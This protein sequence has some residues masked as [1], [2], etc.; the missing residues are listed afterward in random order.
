MSVGRDLRRAV[1]WGLK[2]VGGLLANLALLTIWVDGLG[3]LAWWAVGINWVVMSLV[4]YV[5]ADRWVFPATPSPT[6]VVANARQW[7]RMQ[8][9]MATS[10]VA[11]YLLYL[12]LLPIVDYRLAWAIGAVVTFA[13]TFLGNRLLWAQPQLIS[14]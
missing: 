10:K 7:L 1:R 2:S 4:G 11:N 12:A 6:G 14:R 9:V 3:L 13:V 8:S 5:V